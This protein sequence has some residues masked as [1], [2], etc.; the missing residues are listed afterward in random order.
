MKRITLV[1]LWFTAMAN[2][3]FSYGPKAGLVLTTVKAGNTVG[4]EP[5]SDV[6]YAFG[7][8][9]E[10]KFSDFSVNL[11][12][13]YG[14]YGSKGKTPT[15]EGNNTFDIDLK[16]KMY[17]FDLTANY[18]LTESF[19]IGA[20]GYYGAITDVEYNIADSFEVDMTNKYE[21]SDYGVVFKANYT[22]YK[23]FFAEAKYNFGLANVIKEKP[24]LFQ[25]PDPNADDTV[26]NR[27]L[28]VSVGYRF[29]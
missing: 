15:G 16:Q 6:S 23:G 1:A 28:T 22:L 3:Q 13:S 12:V 26:E 9:S 20:G 25:M 11:G 14:A 2:A 29:K 17:L 21:N 19:S 10:Y 5:E 24:Y 27:F 18:Y 7:A 4:I 8:F